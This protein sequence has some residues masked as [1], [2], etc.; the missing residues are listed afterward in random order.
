[1]KK[2]MVS[3]IMLAL[4]LTSMLMLTF[5]IQPVKS[6][7]ITIPRGAYDR[8]VAYNY[9]GKYWDE[10]CSDG[11][12][13]D[14]P[15]SYIFLDPGTDIT[16][17]TGYDCAHFVS[18]CIGNEPNEQG[19][20]L[21][22]PSRVPP[23]YGEPGAARLGDW[24][25]HSG[26]GVEKTSVAELEMGD[27]INYDWGGD[28]HWDHIALYLGGG[29]VA[30]HTSCVWKADWRLGGADNYRFV[31]IVRLPA[32]DEWPMSHH[33]ERNTEH[34][35]DTRIYPPLSQIWEYDEEYY[36]GARPIASQDAIYVVRFDGIVFKRNAVDGSKIWEKDVGYYVWNSLALG[37]D[38]VFVSMANGTLC[39]LNKNNG[40]IQWRIARGR[41]GI[42]S[43]T[44]VDGIVYVGSGDYN[45]Y[46]I[47]ADNGTEK[48]RFSTESWVDS[49]VAVSNGV[50]YAGSTDKRLYAIDV[51]TGTEKWRFPKTGQL[52]YYVGAPIIGDEIVYALAD[53]LYAL[54]VHTGNELWSASPSPGYSAVESSAIA[55]GIIYMIS[56]TQVYAFNAATG[57]LTWN[58][59]YVETG[60]W[61]SLGVIVA[62]NI[63]YAGFGREAPPGEH[64]FTLVSLDALNGS[65]VWQYTTDMAGALHP[66]IAN[67][68]LYATSLWGN[69]TYCFAPLESP[70]SIYTDKYSYSMGDTMYVGLYVTNPLDRPINV[71]V[72]IWLENP[73]GTTYLILHAHAVTLPAGFSYSNPVF[74]S[75]VLQSIPTGVYTW[76]S[77]LL[78]PST[79]AI[80]VEDT[81]EWTFS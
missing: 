8:L 24:L 23:T 42:S 33:D 18:C 36:M 49:P 54:D 4:L 20:G 65:P 81:A 17:M 73:H 3:G 31:H 37:Q 32:V 45:V 79:H 35:L 5:E 48:W 26:N 75:Y 72:A 66:I 15:T 7:T 30:A 2:R 59:T 9:A 50:V 6:R 57:V 69:N 21:G 47:Y 43:T 76:H 11:Y 40:E 29:E 34:S 25:I 22:V 71:C 80:I 10:V 60:D 14:T 67:G 46:A 51:A 13:W 52:G 56:G 61:F 78:N 74:K 27:V 16:G 68:K 12:F 41:Y 39:A 64:A 55:Y 28:G 62:N 1:M 77:A 58:Y 38:L 70:I 19:G 53:K 63:V 44:Y